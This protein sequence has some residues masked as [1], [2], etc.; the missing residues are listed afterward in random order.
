LLAIDNFSVERG[1]LFRLRSKKKKNSLNSTQLRYDLRILFDVTRK[2]T[3][4][5]KS[6]KRIATKSAKITYSSYFVDKILKL[7]P[8]T[9]SLDRRIRLLQIYK[10][11]TTYTWKI[12]IQTPCVLCFLPEL[13]T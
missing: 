13:Y 3:C 2:R 7:D 1:F 9:V 10:K 11:K 4:D 6:F 5:G 8:Y 12:C